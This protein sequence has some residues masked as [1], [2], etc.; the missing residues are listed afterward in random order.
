MILIHEAFEME[1]ISG[2]IRL[3]SQGAGV[4]LVPR[5]RPYFPLPA[6]VRVIPLNR[7][8]MRRAIG[9]LERKRHAQISH[10]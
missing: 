1:E 9:L 2:L 6:N 4:A 3:L 8:E 7:E 5:C 10:S